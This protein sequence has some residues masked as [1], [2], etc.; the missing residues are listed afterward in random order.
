MAMPT[1]KRP[2][3]KTEKKADAACVLAKRIFEIADDHKASDITV[4]DLR[5]LTSFT[6]YFIIATGMSDSQVR[7]IA[8]SIRK[9]LKRAGKI[10]LSEEGFRSGRWAVL[11][12][13]DVVVHVFY[14]MERAHYSLERL[15]HDAP[16]LKFS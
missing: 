4:L 12:Y 1:R 13:G 7:A 14:H 10:P 9:D 15:W 8:E 6:D 3:K 16:R 5:R 11:D 2:K